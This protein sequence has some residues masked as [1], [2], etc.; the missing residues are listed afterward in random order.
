[1]K[2]KKKLPIVTNIVVVMLCL[3]GLLPP[4]MGFAQQT[5][6]PLAGFHSLEVSGLAKVYIKQGNEEKATLKIAGIPASDVIVVVKDSILKVTTKGTHD[7][8]TVNVFVSYRHL[9]K[10]QLGNA[11]ELHGE[12]TVKATHLDVTV[13]GNAAATLD[14][15]V[16]TLD[17]T[18]KD[19]ADLKISGKTDTRTIHSTAPKGSLDNSALHVTKS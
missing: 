16:T 8:E 5:V 6:Q 11:A 9:Q 7:G 10:I 18:A 3:A 12:N 4:K 17:I 19:A 1:M 15:N 2:E 14:V 13:S